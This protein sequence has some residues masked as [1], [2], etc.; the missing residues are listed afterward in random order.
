MKIILFLALITLA[1]CELYHYQECVR[2]TT[3]LLKEP[4]SSGTY[5]GNSP[6]H[7]L[8]DN[9]FA[10]TCFSTQFAFACPDGVK[11]VYQL[12]ARSVSPKLFIRQEE[13]Q[14]LYSPIFFIVAAIV[15]ITLCFI[16]KRKTE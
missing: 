15:F 11:H 5:E 16:L 6:F 14:E 13:V 2:G 7:P 4:C 12:R 9:K 10:L 8:A 3:V 1:T